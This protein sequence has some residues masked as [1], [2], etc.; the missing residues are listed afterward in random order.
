MK[1]YYTPG[2]CSLAP[3]IVLCESGLPYILE[4]VDL[5]NKTIADGRDFLAINPLGYVPVLELN[6]GEM[7]T[8][9][10]AILFYLADRVPN[11][12]LVPPAGEVARYR[13]LAWLNF[14]GSE[15]HKNFSPLFGKDTPAEY[16]AQVSARLATR[17]AH[18]DGVLAYSPYLADG[19]FTIADAYLFVVS[20]WAA[21][22]GFD[23]A[24]YPHLLAFRERV[25]ARPSVQ[26]AMQEEGL[27]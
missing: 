17:F 12:G 25:A 1:L 7:L 27:L 8:E 3:H 14:I 26:R 16:K 11:A 6:N 20:N 4:R 10:T 2:A 5:R 18:V 19:V 9:V 13:L 24:P 15:L 22:V 21:I 23:L